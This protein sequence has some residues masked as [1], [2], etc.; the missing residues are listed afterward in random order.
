MRL[1]DLARS[2]HFIRIVEVFPPAIPSPHEIKP[3]QKFD[4]NIRFDRLVQGLIRTEP[5]ADA[6]SLPELKDGNRIHL[7]SVGIATELKRRTGSS[8]IPTVTL[9]DAN[10]HNLFGTITYALFAGIENI[11][12]VRG[13]PYGDDGAKAPKNVYDI[14]KVSNL[15]STARKLESHIASEHQLCI[16]SPI[17]LAKS[18]D[19]KYLETLKERELSGVDIF[20]GEQMF[21][22]LD[23][24]LARIDAIRKY[25]IRKP[26]VHSIFPLKDHEDAS[27]LVQK[28]G[29]GIRD[30]ELA[31]LKKGGPK[32]GIEMAR[33]RYRS[34]F[35]HRDL[36]EGVSV[37]TRGNP[38]VA[39]YIF[40]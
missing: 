5:F 40:R 34:L 11:L 12:F 16:L 10:K 1:S 6:F 29:W 31:N 2:G 20:I 18:D 28:F 24:Y 35:K 22:D 33:D 36:V 27:A 15:I 38:E 37:S 14:E 17:N 19:K 13:D 4:L 25:G 26:I 32:Y 30:S 8:V 7:N 3:I 21:E 23:V 39:R 9:R